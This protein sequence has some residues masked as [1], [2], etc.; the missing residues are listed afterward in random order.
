MQVDRQKIFGFGWPIPFVKNS[1]TLPSIEVR[2]APPEDPLPQVSAEIALLDRARLREEEYFMNR[3]QDEYN[4]QLN[5]AQAEIKDA[6]DKAIRVFFDPR[7]SAFTSAIKGAL[8]PLTSPT[9]TSAAMRF[10]PQS[11]IPDISGG[12]GASLRSRFTSFI[13]TGTATLTKGKGKLLPLGNIARTL[14]RPREPSM[15]VKLTDIKAPSRDIK[16]KIDQIEQKRSDEERKMIEQAI[17]EM[18]QLTKITIQE[19]K[20]IEIQEN[21]FIVDSR[22]PVRQVAKLLRGRRVPEF[23]IVR[24]QPGRAAYASPIATRAG[25]TVPGGAGGALLRFQQRHDRVMESHHGSAMKGYNGKCLDIQHRFPHFRL[26]CRIH[27]ATAHIP[28][29][30]LTSFIEIQHASRAN[31]SSASS[32][33]PLSKLGGLLESQLN[34]KVTQSDQPYPTVDEL[35]ADMEKRRDVAERLER[36]KILELELKLMKAEN[37]MIKDALRSALSRVMAQYEP[38]VTAI[39]ELLAPITLGRG[40]ATGA[41]VPFPIPQQ[42]STVVLNAAPFEQMAKTAAVRTT[43]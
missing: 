4:R 36:M 3:L 17:Q 7:G 14:I 31:A 25:G 6:I 12:I 37:D 1:Q 26:D 13:E 43:R 27:K 10:Q 21:P 20:N 15:K 24:I 22:M 11:I 30:M 9:A 29:R 34:V 38:A 2:L 18:S 5:I 33:N 40:S 41:K 28:T 19:S 23:P 32:L 35:V 39:K 16:S 8:L 42:Q